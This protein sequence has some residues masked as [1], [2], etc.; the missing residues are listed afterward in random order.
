MSTFTIFADTLDGQRHAAPSAVRINKKLNKFGSLRKVLTPKN[1]RR[2]KVKSQKK[3]AFAAATKV[4]K[5]IVTTRT[6]LSSKVKA[7]EKESHKISSPFKENLTAKKINDV[8]AD[9]ATPLVIKKPPTKL[10]QHSSAF[11]PSIHKLLSKQKTPLTRE[12][13]VVPDMPTL[14]SNEDFQNWLDKHVYSLSPAQP[15]R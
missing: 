5:K 11:T 6:P 13:I 9:H 8:T 12:S 2:N 3:S 15:M 10:S 7:V 14:L 4:T 1:G